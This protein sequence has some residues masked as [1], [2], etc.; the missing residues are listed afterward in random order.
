MK[1]SI[2]R[3]MLTLTAAGAIMAGYGGM[4]TAS[5]APVPSTSD[6][7]LWV[8][9]TCGENYEVW[10]NCVAEAGGGSGTGYTFTWDTGKVTS[11]GTTSQAKAYCPENSGYRY[12]SVS[13]TDSNNASAS[14]QVQIWCSPW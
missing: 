3:A 7:P 12:V 9:A 11:G 8:T 4:P 2:I 10:Q 6:T 5:A 1:S 13:V 14:T